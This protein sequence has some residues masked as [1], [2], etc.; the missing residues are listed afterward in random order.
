MTPY[1]PKRSPVAYRWLAFFIFSIWLIVGL[2]QPVLAQSA[3]GFLSVDGPCQF[4][5]PTDHGPHPGYRT[6]WWYY[7]GNLESDVRKQYGFQLTFFRV[8]ISP[9]CEKEDWP[10]RPS[11][12]RTNHI[13]FSHAAITDVADQRHYQAQEAAR[14]ALGMSGVSQ[15]QD[16][17]TL[18]IKNWQVVIETQEHRL[19]AQT[20]DFDIELQ[21][22]PLKPPVSHGQ[23]GYSQKGS[24][25]QR[26][27]CYYSFTRLATKGSIRIGKKTSHVDGLSWMDH[28]YSTAPLEPGIVGWDWFSLQLSD[29]TEVMMF[30]LRKA[31]GTTHPAS[32]GTVVNDKADIQH[33]KS[34][35]FSIQVQDSWLSPATRARY[36]SHWRIRIPAIRL[37]L[38]VHP[39]VADQEM[40]TQATTGVTYWEGSIKAV[41]TK[42]G[43]PL[44]AKGYVEMTGYDKNFDAPL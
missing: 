34:N 4:K 22:T 2:S 41:G 26:A 8:Q 18:F 42:E 9:T 17:T 21:L 30:L 37:D 36:P 35:Q 5:F 32:S 23:N 40:Q 12:W 27:S 29:Q 13:Y 38:D 14:N 16:R 28:E 3:C 39:A 33:L 19:S 7:T 10:E 25:P 20:P 24:S 44:N 1:P 6:E 43:L 31:D 11:A 15:A